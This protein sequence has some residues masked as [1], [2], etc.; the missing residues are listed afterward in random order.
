MFHY[1]LYCICGRRIGD[2]EKEEACDIIPLL[3]FTE[4]G[5]HRL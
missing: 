5:S 4:A 2:K 1:T 3:L